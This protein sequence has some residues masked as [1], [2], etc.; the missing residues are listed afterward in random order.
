[1]ISPLRITA[2]CR[3]DVEVHLPG[4]VVPAGALMIMER[5]AFEAMTAEL[6]GLDAD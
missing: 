5:S 2:P 4:R 3:L 1:M 6:A